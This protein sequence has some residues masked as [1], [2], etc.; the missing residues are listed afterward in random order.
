[1]PALVITSKIVAKVEGG[2]TKPDAEDSHNTTTWTEVVDSS[3]SGESIPDGYSYY[4]G[5]TLRSSVNGT[6]AFLEFR[7][8]DG[9]TVLGNA[10]TTSI[11]YTKIKTP[12]LKNVSGAPITGIRLFIK[13]T[14]T[15]ICYIQGTS[16]YWVGA[17]SNNTSDVI[18]VKRQVDNLYIFG[19]AETINGN[20]ANTTVD[21]GMTVIPI[22]GIMSSFVFSANSGNLIFAWDGSTIGVSP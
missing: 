15:R 20:I 3:G 8:S 22:D 5:A 11:N 19:S 16:F 10:Q 6:I 7:E 4:L 1:M 9:V 21:L 17:E 13:A 14:S 12:V 18:G 2:G